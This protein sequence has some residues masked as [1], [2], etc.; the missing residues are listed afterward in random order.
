MCLSSAPPTYPHV[1]ETGS[2][3][4]QDIHSLAKCFGHHP[5]TRL[6]W[7]SLLAIA[8]S[9][10]TPSIG[11]PYHGPCIA[12]HPFAVIHLHG[13][14]GQLLYYDGSDRSKLVTT[15]PPALSRPLFEPVS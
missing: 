10:K 1:A 2:L 14:G 15:T 12:T 11:A 3:F 7:L 6:R 8:C 4:K 13:C 9:T 5:G